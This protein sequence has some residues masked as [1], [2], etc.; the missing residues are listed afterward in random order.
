VCLRL[1]RSLI[2]TW[3]VYGIKKPL[4]IHGS[5]SKT[6]DMLRCCSSAQ[7][8]NDFPGYSYMCFDERRVL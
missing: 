7:L 4:Q 6:S 1:N 8:S 2:D 3:R 5:T